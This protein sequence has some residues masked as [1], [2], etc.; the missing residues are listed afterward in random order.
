MPRASNGT[1]TLPQSAFVPGTVISSSA[2]N[3]DFSDIASALTDSL[4]RSGDGGMT[5]PLEAADGTV[6]LPGYTFG[7]DPNTGLYRVSADSIA[8]VTGGV[9]ALTVDS[10]QNV[11]LAA[12][13]T[14]TGTT[15]IG[16]I[17]GTGLTLTDT[18]AGATEG[19]VANLFRN[20][21]SPAA[22]DVLGAILFTGK[23][24]GGGTDTYAE[25]STSIVAASAGTEAGSIDFATKVSGTLATR[26]YIRNGLVMGAAT[27]GDQGAGT[28]NATGLFVNGVAA[29]G[30][31]VARYYATY[32]ANTSISANI[33]YD[34]SIP[35]NGEGTQILSITIN[36]LSSATNRIRVTCMGFGSRE[37]GAAD[38]MT[39]A[40]FWDSVADAL[41]ASA[42][43]GG[44]TNTVAGPFNLQFEHVPGDTAAHTYNIRVG[45]SSGNMRMNGTGGGRLYGGIAATTLII[46]ELQP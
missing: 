45:T 11:T 39:M 32:T 30:K 42:S 8:I 23:D 46:E 21:A 14:V 35:Q 29:S 25:I 1:Y 5:A 31:L 9:A 26:G 4:S 33:P 28:V 20:S 34:D 3:S 13:L 22:S 40:L 2:V 41:Q 7:T 27:G 37:A 18:G 36:P 17:A 43:P 24:D 10:S 16:A 44:L 12:N 38:S 19:P 6:S 15:N